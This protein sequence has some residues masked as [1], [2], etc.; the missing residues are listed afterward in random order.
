MRDDNILTFIRFASC[1]MIRDHKDNTDFFLHHGRQFIGEFSDAL[2]VET[3][4]WR[5]SHLEQDC[6]I[7][8]DDN[9][10][11]GFCG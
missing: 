9:A 3:M 8:E 2:E 10:V 11:N 4:G 5:D 7:F 1:V 6:D